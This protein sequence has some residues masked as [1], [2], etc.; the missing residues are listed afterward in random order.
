MVRDTSVQAYRDIKS[1]GAR[2]KVV[3][4]VIR[5]LGAPT[6]SEICRYLG[7]PINTITPRTYELV[8]KGMVCDAGKKECPVTGRIAYAWRVK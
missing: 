1:L 6:N 7:L 4:D 5:Y 2:Q 8:K 3:L